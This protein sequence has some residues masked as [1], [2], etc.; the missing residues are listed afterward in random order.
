MADSARTAVVGVSTRPICGVRDHALLL[1]EA[2]ARENVACSMHWL[3]SDERSLAR[4]RA[5]IRTWT[6]ALATELDG[7]HLDAILLHYS[8]FAYSYRGVPLFVHPTVAALRATGAP[9][10]AIMHE[11]A[12]PWRRGGL[13]GNMW[14]ATQRAALVEVMRTS[15]AVI[16]TADF[17]AEWLSSRPWLPS[18]P[19]AVAPVFSNLPPSAA[20]PPPDR[21]VPVLG[22]FGYTLDPATVSLVIDAV[23]RLNQRGVRLQLMLLGAPGRSSPVARMWT[24]VAESRA[25]AQQLSFSG[26]LSA[27]ELSDAL[28][29]ADLLLYADRSGPASRKGTLAASLASGRPVIALEGRRGWQQLLDSEAALVVPRT[30]DAL[31]AAV[32]TLLVDRSA[33]DA[34]GARGGAFAEHAIGVARTAEVV[35]VLVDDML[36]ERRS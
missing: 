35:R 18:R 6:R 16:V 33:R 3:S 14:A 21:L 29:S 24:K 32:E 15:S 12:F 28:A 31:V 11:I 30:P 36:G 25:V 7:A 5:E 20:E 1:A 27:Q 22:L 23:C 19:V 17:R 4:S 8:I 9:V 26:T 13:K 2:L 10:I 34:L